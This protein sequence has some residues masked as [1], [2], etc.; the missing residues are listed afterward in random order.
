[1]ERISKS[2]FQA[3][4]PEVFRRLEETGES[5][6]ITQDGGPVA[7]LTPVSSSASGPDPHAILAELRGTLIRYDDPTEP[8]GLEDWESV[9]EG[10][11]G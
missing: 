9:D 3:E 8:V 5:L 2:R 1:M 4:A 6:L 11:N 10:H 7:R